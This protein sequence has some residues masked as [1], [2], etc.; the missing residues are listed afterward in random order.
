MIK[1]LTTIVIIS[2]FA[3]YNK[4]VKKGEVKPLN[5]KTQLIL[6]GVGVLL[7]FVILITLRNM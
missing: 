6:V 5:P 2:A 4:R 1:I 7:A 3:L